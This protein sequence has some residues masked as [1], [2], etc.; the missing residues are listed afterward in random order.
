LANGKYAT[1]TGGFCDLGATDYGAMSL[2][3][4]M[5]ACYQPYDCIIINYG[6]NYTTVIARLS[7]LTTLFHLS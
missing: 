6:G 1:S 7:T 3:D 5:M 2:E 4:C